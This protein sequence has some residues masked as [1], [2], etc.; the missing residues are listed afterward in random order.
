MNFSRNKSYFLFKPLAYFVLWFFLLNNLMPI[1]LANAQEIFS[2]PKPNVMLGLSSPFT[3][4]ILKGLKV[5]THNP[6]EFDFIIDS[7]SNKLQV[8]AV[9]DQNEHIQQQLKPESE[10]LI[11][12]FL[13]SLTIPEDDLWVNLS[14]YESGKIV[15]AQLGQT[16]MGRDLLAQDYLLKQ[17]SSSL[18]Y[19]ENEIGKKFWERVYQK[20]YEKFGRTDVPIN[21]FNKIWIVPE[22]AV[23]YENGAN[24]FVVESSLKVMLEE[25]YL[26]KQEEGKSNPIAKIQQDDTSTLSSQI[27]RDVMIP[28]IEQ[29][30]NEGALFSQLRQIYSALILATWYKKALKESL[31][32][33]IYV[34]QKK[35]KG[36]ETN[37]PGVINK[38]YDQYVQAFKEGVYNFIKEDYDPYTKENIP[39]KYFSGGLTLKLKDK[40][41]YVTTLGH[42]NSTDLFSVHAG[43]NGLAPS[44]VIPLSNDIIREMKLKPLDG[45][46][47]L[48]SQ[49]FGLNI[50]PKTNDVFMFTSTKNDE[51]TELE[52]HCREFVDQNL[53]RVLK[54]FH[55]PGK[56]QTR[57]KVLLIQEMVDIKMTDDPDL[58]DELI[59]EYVIVEFVEKDVD[60]LKNTRVPDDTEIKITNKALKML[61]AIN[62]KWKL[63]DAPTVSI[64]MSSNFKDKVNGRYVDLFHTMV[65]KEDLSEDE[66]LETILHEWL[67]HFFEGFEAKWLDE[68]TI[69]YL[70]IKLLI[71]NNALPQQPKQMP[72]WSDKIEKMVFGKLFELGKIGPVSQYIV[73]HYLNQG[74]VSYPIYTIIV[75]YLVEQILPK[76]NMDLPS[77]LSDF[78]FGRK[79]KIFEQLTSNSRNSL[80]ELIEQAQNSKNF[81]D[82]P[83]NILISTEQRAQMEQIIAS[84]VKTHPWALKAPHVVKHVT[85]VLNLLLLTHQTVMSSDGVLQITREHFQNLLELQER[86]R[87]ANQA[88]DKQTRAQLENELARMENDFDDKLNEIGRAPI[89]LLMLGKDGEP[90]SAM[91]NQG[92]SEEPSDQFKS[93]LKHTIR[94]LDPE[95]K[96]FETGMTIGGLKTIFGIEDDLEMAHVDDFRI[97]NLNPKYID[98]V[99]YLGAKEFNNSLESILKII[100]ILE[101]YPHILL[102]V[103]GGTTKVAHA[104]ALKNQN[105]GVI[106]FD[107]YDRLSG[108]Y[109][110]WG[111]DFQRNA[112]IAQKNALNNLVVVRA[113]QRMLRYLPLNAVDDI[114]F[115]NPNFLLAEIKLDKETQRPL[116]PNGRILQKPYDHRQFIDR[117]TLEAILA[118]EPDFFNAVAL[119]KK[120]SKF[121]IH[122][123]G[124]DFQPPYD[125][126]ERSLPGIIR[127][128]GPQEEII[129]GYTFTN[130]NTSILYGVD[131]EPLAWQNRGETLYEWRK[132]HVPIKPMSDKLLLSSPTAASETNDFQKGGIDLNPIRSQLDVKGNE[133]KPVFNFNLNDLKKIN[134]EGLSPFIINISPITNLPLFLS[135]QEEDQQPSEIR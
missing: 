54:K 134:I 2:L 129:Q 29:E 43:T 10:K 63:P 42:Q 86:M 101:N 124:R 84:I 11:K 57:S 33:Q 77:F 72:E 31:I 130:L 37:D 88:G 123:L 111:R 3:P 74:T 47:E 59:L 65:I 32:S 27:V 96:I 76:L 15:P 107:K 30:V 64:V 109:G 133:Q 127:I 8:N 71:E 21:T 40:E 44:G 53:D 112:L 70:T 122:V 91:E 73:S 38:I 117:G 12:Y 45:S 119:A 41:Q 108:D 99:S 46:L 58:S 17:L 131:I 4:V 49:N 120:R 52:N 39:R 135:Y 110:E 19:P 80:F 67:H 98:L 7:G 61:E 102:E 6:F 92:V 106:T 114:L 28:A 25:D 125:P 5:N 60:F 66:M 78:K 97:K 93:K 82:W 9:G 100:Y 104:L 90:A 116:K 132:E 83:E 51:I 22:K 81:Y 68:G 75:E 13:A 94:N 95:T 23:V 79:T 24:A 36:V 55:V 121:P 113:D 56:L 48:N 105:I 85:D 35:V 50:T 62:E 87:A 34:D 14:V 1:P 20:V 26:A 115:V 69:E 18:L 126:H 118:V 103:G 16:E 128:K 89:D